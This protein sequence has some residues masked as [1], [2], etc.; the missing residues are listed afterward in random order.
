MTI[1]SKRD[2][3]N[4]FTF[5]FLRVR[6][7]DHHHSRLSFKYGSLKRQLAWLSI[8]ARNRD[9][10]IHLSQALKLSN[11]IVRKFNTTG[12]KLHWWQQL[13]IFHDFKRTKILSHLNCIGVATGM[14]GMNTLN[15][16]QTKQ[17]LR[18]WLE[19]T[20]GE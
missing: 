1:E 3:V 6:L 4:T 10:K 9:L 8:K 19:T 2:E 15:T 16:G 5:T 13:E 11:E 14:S 20:I 17:T 18:A 12:R 7:E